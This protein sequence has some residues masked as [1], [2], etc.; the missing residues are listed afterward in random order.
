M[1]GSIG[2]PAVLDL[3][4]LGGPGRIGAWRAGEVLIDCGPATTLPRLLAACGDWRPEAILLTH[5]HFDHAGAI[6][7][8]V[9][10]WPGVEVCV[11]QR[12]AKHLIAPERLEASARRV[13]GKAFDEKFGALEPVP[14]ESIRV[15]HDGDEVHGFQAA[16]TPGHASHHL[17]FFHAPTGWCFPGDVMGVRLAKDGPV[18]LPTP[19]PDIDLDLWSASVDRVSAWEPITFGLPHF[20]RFED[21]P[22]HVGQVRRALERHREQ[23][24]H[25]PGQASFIN[26]TRRSLGLDDRPELLHDYETVVPLEQNYVGLL[27]AAGGAITSASPRSADTGGRS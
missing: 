27:R 7:Q 5:I 12:G 1:S 11:H 2:Q 19:P 16:E 4:W 21:V 24:E 17:A 10:H 25:P 22:F 18:L 14:A 26:E 3:G 15:V 20:G 13:F 6:G 9:R 8:L 23:F